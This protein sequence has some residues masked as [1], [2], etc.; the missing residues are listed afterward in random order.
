MLLVLSG[1][2]VCLIITRGQTWDPLR[3]LSVGSTVVGVKEAS[4][5]RGS[6]RASNSS[7]LDRAKSNWKGLQC[8]LQAMRCES[9]VR[10]ESSRISHCWMPQA[11]SDFR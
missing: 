5:S 4:Q 2:S 9:R 8:R 7:E 3:T 10:S 6:R 1:A 11:H